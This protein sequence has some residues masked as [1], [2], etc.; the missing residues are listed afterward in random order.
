MIDKIA[1]ERIP[2]RPG[3]CTSG[4]CLSR[5]GVRI[6]SRR[7]PSCPDILSVAG[8][9]ATGGNEHA[10]RYRPRHALGAAD[11]QPDRLGAGGSFRPIDLSL[12]I[13]ILG[14]MGATW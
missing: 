5:A 11:V 7:C 3:W 10:A 8:G 14:K 2:T 6:V 13:G 1:S 9:D 4:A 12:P